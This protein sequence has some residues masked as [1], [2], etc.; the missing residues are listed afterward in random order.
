MRMVSENL[1]VIQE[2]EML[3]QELDVSRDQLDNLQKNH[4]VSETKSK[5][6]LK[7][8]VKEVKS[9]RNSQSDL[10]QE[11]SNLMKVKIELEVILCPK[12]M[13]PFNFRQFV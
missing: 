12:S 8:L 13:Y 11:L 10:K 3:R 4:E 7:V 6:D 9:L 5:T 1:A 2:I